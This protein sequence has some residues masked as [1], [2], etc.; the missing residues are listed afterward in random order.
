MDEKEKK[1]EDLE[2]EIENTIEQQIRE[3]QE[4]KDKNNVI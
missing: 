2:R 1:I 4:L 3:N